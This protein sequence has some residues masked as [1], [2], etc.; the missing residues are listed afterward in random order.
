M[1]VTIKDIAIRTGLAISTISKYLNGGNVLPENQVKI[2]KTIDELGFSANTFARGLKTNKSY[3]IGIVAES[4][5]DQMQSGIISR[6]E[7]ILRRHG[8]TAVITDCGYDVEKQ[9]EAVEYLISGHVDAVVIIPMSIDNGMIQLCREHEIPV[10][11]VLNKPE[12]TDVDCVLLDYYSAAYSAVRHFISNHHR[13]IA[14]IGG[15]EN[16]NGSKLC[17]QGYSTAMKNAQLPLRE[18]YFSFGGG[19]AASGYE[20]LKIMMSQPEPPRAVLLADFR[21]T[22]GGLLAAK[23]LGL[24]IPGELAL[25]GFGNVE[26]AQTVSPKLHVMVNPLDR[27]ASAVSSLLMERMAEKTPSPIQIYKFPTEFFIGE[28]V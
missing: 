13:N 9:L 1:A 26:L 11:A 17:C 22:V 24:D 4:L 15:A 18:E 21:I 3:R 28:S 2:Q 25:I 14:I 5:E 19:S 6:L 27:I 10:I 8:Y 7:P 16:D 23:E 20:R 12:D